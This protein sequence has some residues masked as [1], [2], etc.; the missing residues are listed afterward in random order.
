MK[1]ITKARAETKLKELEDKIQL[2]VMSVGIALLEIQNEQLYKLKHE[3]F[4]SYCQHVWGFSR[5][6]AYQLIEGAQVQVNCQPV[7]DKVP[8]KERHLREISKIPDKKQAQ[9]VAGVLEKCE[10]ENRAPTTADYRKAVLPF[11]DQKEPKDKPDPPKSTQVDWK[12]Q[13]SKA[14][15]TANALQRAIDDLHAIRGSG[16]PRRHAN[17]IE[18]TQQVLVLLEGW[19]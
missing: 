9:V 16:Q 18:K 10:A 17:A 8:T 1:K 11:V 3:T 15:A 2:G 19:T 7:V 12:K 13:R 14:V 5:Q 6:R 4:E